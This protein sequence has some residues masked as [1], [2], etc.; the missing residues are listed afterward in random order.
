MNKR[1]KSISILI[2]IS[3]NMFSLI[4]NIQYNESDIKTNPIIK[5]YDDFNESNTFGDY[6]DV[7][8]FDQREDYSINGRPISSQNDITMIDGTN[9]NIGTGNF[10]TGSSSG[11]QFNPRISSQTIIKTGDV[12]YFR[13][14]Q[15]QTVPT[16]SYVHALGYTYTSV[17]QWGSYTLWK[18]TPEYHMVPV[19]N[20]PN[21]YVYYQGRLIKSLP[22]LTPTAGH[23]QYLI[24]P[25]FGPSID[26]I[27]L[28]RYDGYTKVPDDIMGRLESFG[29]YLSDGGKITAGAPAMDAPHFYIDAKFSDG[30]ITPVYYESRTGFDT[31]YKQKVEF[32]KY[33]A[34]G[35]FDENRINELRGSISYEIPIDHYGLRYEDLSEVSD[36]LSFRAKISMAKIETGNVVYVYRDGGIKTKTVFSMWPETAPFEAR[37]RII[38]TTGAVS[39]SSWYDPTF[40]SQSEG[41]D[42]ITPLSATKKNEIALQI[43]SESASTSMNPK[44]LIQLE[45][46]NKNEGR[47]LHYI[48]EGNN[49][50]TFGFT[51]PNSIQ[52]RIGLNFNE[53]SNSVLTAGIDVTRLDLFI[54]C[55]M[56]Q[57]FAL[58]Q[59]S[60]IGG[61]N[62]GGAIQ[63]SS[64]TTIRSVN[65]YHSEQVSTSDNLL[66]I[67]IIDFATPI[68]IRDQIMDDLS[69]SYL[70]FYLNHA[71]LDL[72]DDNFQLFEMYW[73]LEGYKEGDGEL[74]VKIPSVGDMSDIYW[75]YRTATTKLMNENPISVSFKINNPYAVITQYLS[76]ERTSISPGTPKTYYDVT[77]N[78]QYNPIVEIKTPNPIYNLVDYFIMEDGFKILNPEYI[79]ADVDR[80]I[81]L[82]LDN[83]GMPQ[84]GD[85]GRI[86][87]YSFSD[88]QFDFENPI[89]LTEG[90]RT[91]PETIGVPLNP[92]L[93]STGQSIYEVY[94][95]IPA[96]IN[97][98]MTINS[99]ANPK[100]IGFSYINTDVSITRYNTMAEMITPSLIDEDYFTVRY[101]YQAPLS[102][103]ISSKMLITALSPLT[104]RYGTI[105]DQQLILN[106]ALNGTLE[107][108][109]M[110]ISSYCISYTG[111]SA[112]PSIT[113]KLTIENTG[114][115][116]AKIFPRFYLAP[117]LSSHLEYNIANYSSNGINFEI[118]AS[119]SET[120]TFNIPV[121]GN[122]PIRNSYFYLYIDFNA[123]I[124]EDTYDLL[125]PFEFSDTYFIYST[126]KGTVIDQTEFNALSTDE[127]E[128]YTYQ[129]SRITYTDQ[130]IFVINF[131]NNEYLVPTRDTDMEYLPPD[132]L[133]PE[134]TT[135]IGPTYDSTLIAGPLDLSFRLTNVL[136]VSDVSMNLKYRLQ[137]EMIGSVLDMGDGFYYRDYT[138]E[139]SRLD[140]E[141]GLYGKRYTN[142]DF[143]THRNENYLQIIPS[144]DEYYMHVSAVRHV[145]GDYYLYNARE[146]KFTYNPSIEIRPVNARTPQEFP[147]SLKYD[148]YLSLK[149]FG[150]YYI[151]DTNVTANSRTNGYVTNYLSPLYTPMNYRIDIGEDNLD[152]RDWK[153]IKRYF[154]DSASYLIEELPRSQNNIIYPKET[155]G[156][157]TTWEFPNYYQFHEISFSV[158]T[159]SVSIENFVIESDSLTE[160]FEAT[161]YIENPRRPFYNVTG[162]V[163][164][165]VFDSD[166]DLSLQILYEGT[167][168][169]VTDGFDIEFGEIQT[170]QSLSLLIEEIGANENIYLKVLGI[171]QI[172]ER[173][174][175]SPLIFGLAAAVMAG[176][177]W[178]VF[179]YR[180]KEYSEQFDTIYSKLG[181]IKY[182]LAT[183][184]VI[185]GAFSAFYIFLRYF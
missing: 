55:T 125:N 133:I 140:N 37:L 11:I 129:F 173:V 112:N 75:D 113:L 96:G 80:Y 142:T 45:F 153:I 151:E 165:P 135:R 48:V 168:I 20:L 171:R 73:E 44:L 176:L 139:L 128:E 97:L 118:D 115:E 50:L 78:N 143:I 157:S 134:I 72:R 161:L 108:T 184:G 144:S 51:S 100:L 158:Q 98:V 102:S 53:L 59:F 170:T 4:L 38:G 15:T 68:N 35:N 114:A 8:T 76:N 61:S 174:D 132:L 137:P 148:P 169:N 116:I 69:S 41:Y 183:L 34:L 30:K 56:P 103:E 82:Y 149:T 156:A 6:L 64:T 25:Y 95:N 150:Y 101:S 104:D 66:R 93:T 46:R 9:Q 63:F 141:P 126:K 60:N 12:K 67:R 16:Y 7:G 99:I 5:E 57:G 18:P 119:S 84:L 52:S 130:T 74:F 181:T 85:P 105:P 131:A 123:L 22:N 90:S 127:L 14:Y 3:F 124:G 89:S 83:K 39:L 107:L 81:Q 27:P 163:S 33:N 65:N 17:Q 172:P 106:H 122:M 177:L 40:I 19:N 28:T 182:I 120:L 94:G 179:T 2:L 47:G 175:N 91:Y 145:I 147:D 13:A 43:I 155:I 162:I 166:Y 21:E 70:L 136:D 178:V 36:S 154:D 180:S 159:P 42:F 167:Y 58:S 71:Y 109:N 88:G 121:V 54:R 62:K 23:T 160:T 110:N 87:A 26:P 1:F 111:W 31:L 117:Y 92:K 185:V 24:E 146:F 152:A 164:I 77:I 86:D 138:D 32:L 29:D 79:A 49:R 10:I